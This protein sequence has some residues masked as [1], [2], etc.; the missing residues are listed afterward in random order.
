MPQV[1]V[2]S[3]RLMKASDERELFL[4]SGGVRD[5]AIPA[6]QRCFR[7]FGDGGNCAAPGQRSCPYDLSCDLSG[8]KTVRVP[9]DEHDSVLQSSRRDAKY[10]AGDRLSPY[11]LPDGRNLANTCELSIIFS[12]ITFLL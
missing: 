8:G 7:S 6:N 10:A 1:R 4:F 12:V 11:T 2:L 5:A 9:E 3:S